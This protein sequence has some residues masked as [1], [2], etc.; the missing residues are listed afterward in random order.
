MI[1]RTAYDTKIG[2]SLNVK[3]V[4]AALR[5]AIVRDR[6]DMVDLGVPAL[7]DFKPVFVTGYFS[8]ES[9]IPLFAHPMIIADV[10]G[11]QYLCTDIRPFIKTAKTMDEDNHFNEPVIRLSSEY[12]LHKGRTILNLQWLN[13]EEQSIRLGLSFASLVYANWISD[14]VSNNFAL[15]G[16]ERLILQVIAFTFHQM[17]HYDW[18]TL[19]E[20]NKELLVAQAEIRFT[21][22]NGNAFI[23]DIIAKLTMMNDMNDFCTNVRNVLENIRLKDF[24]AGILVTLIGSTWHSY[25]GKEIIAVALEHPP[26]WD[27]IVFVAANNKSYNNYGIS[28]LVTRL[29]KREAVTAFSKEYMG[30]VSHQTH[31]PSN[32]FRALR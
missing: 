15:D 4:Q 28:R 16:R 19:S 1:F 7:G 27:S 31:K 32:D 21:F 3:P 18:K 29:N 6:I 13:H 22:P 2:E 12:Q 24:N 5:D 17:Q 14:A 20:N 10:R 26:T 23:S 9:N 8:S 11:Q 30:L 25:N